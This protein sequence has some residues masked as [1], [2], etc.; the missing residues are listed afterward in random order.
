MPSP[1]FALFVIRGEGMSTKTSERLKEW[2]RDEENR[3]K[4]IAAALKATKASQA[5]SDQDKIASK[6]RLSRRMAEKRRMK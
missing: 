6:R 5:I 3:K 2:W 4:G 1:M